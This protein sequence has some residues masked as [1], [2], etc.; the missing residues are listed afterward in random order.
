MKLYQ[1]NNEN[2]VSNE[3]E[4]GKTV[5]RTPAHKD[6]IRT[7]RNGDWWTTQVLRIKDRP[8]HIDENNDLGICWN[9]Y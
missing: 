2:N 5:K 7:Y 9:F 8:N 4:H 3:R 1:Q 6:E